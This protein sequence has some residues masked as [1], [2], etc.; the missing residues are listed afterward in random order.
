VFADNGRWTGTYRLPEPSTDIGRFTGVHL[1]AS[2]H[3]DEG[4]REVAF[5]NIRSAQMWT[6]RPAVPRGHP[7]AG[8]LLGEQELGKVGIPKGKSH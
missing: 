2:G 1:T 6:L 4:P 3:N 7:V 5:E 8:K